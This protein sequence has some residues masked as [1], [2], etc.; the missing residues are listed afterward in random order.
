L[1]PRAGFKT[2]WDSLVPICY[3]LKKNIKF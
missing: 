2:S 3:A 1:A